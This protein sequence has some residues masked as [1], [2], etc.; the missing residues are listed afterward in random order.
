MNWLKNIIYRWLFIKEGKDKPSD[1]VII[2]IDK[3][4][5]KG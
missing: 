4:I 2:N 5:I 3:V 1:Q